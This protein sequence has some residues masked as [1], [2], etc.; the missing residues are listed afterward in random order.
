MLRGGNDAHLPFAGLL[1]L[2]CTSSP[3]SLVPLQLFTMSLL[4]HLLNTVRARASKKK[5]LKDGKPRLDGLD[6]PHVVEM[7]QSITRLLGGVKAQ[8]SLKVN[9]ELLS[10]GLHRLI[11]GV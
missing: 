8:S 9:L 11:P 5:L 6:D 7:H 10:S 1:A 4:S 2:V 3:P